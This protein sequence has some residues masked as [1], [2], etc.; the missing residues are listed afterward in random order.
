MR[1]RSSGTAEELDGQNLLRSETS[2]NSSTVLGEVL[3]NDEQNLTQS[4]AVHAWSG[5]QRRQG[6]RAVAILGF[7]E[8]HGGAQ[9]REETEAVHDDVRSYEDDAEK[10]RRGCSMRCAA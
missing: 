9:R 5:G 4:C 7:R 1:G 10:Q 2:G 3:D 6:C 8:A